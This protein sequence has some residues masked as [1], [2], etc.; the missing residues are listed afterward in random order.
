MLLA[1]EK[2]IDG[3][4]QLEILQP[5]PGSQVG[6]IVYLEGHEQPTEFPE[7]INKKQ[8]DKIIKD[9]KIEGL[10]IVGVGMR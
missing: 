4:L 5:P 9:W 1:G 2:V 8:W 10:S 7:Q 3:T 6:D